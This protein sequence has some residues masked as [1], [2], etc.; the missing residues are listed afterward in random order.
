MKVHYHLKEGRIKVEVTLD[1]MITGWSS[2]LTLEEVSLAC[3]VVVT[4]ETRA[5]DCSVG[6]APDPIRFVSTFL[7]LPTRIGHR[8]SCLL[9]GRFWNK[10]IPNKLSAREPMLEAYGTSLNHVFGLF[11]GDGGFNG[12]V[13]CSTVKNCVC[14]T[15]M[16][17]FEGALPY[18]SKSKMPSFTACKVIL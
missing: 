3:W 2:S 1:P 11:G 8:G 18:C 7:P 12:Y 5:G 13:F 14:Q 10:L 6:I 15:I 16:D 4:A 9:R 17:R